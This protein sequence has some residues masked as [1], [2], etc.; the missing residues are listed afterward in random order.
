[1]EWSACKQDYALYGTE[2]Y[3]LFKNES[4]QYIFIGVE[5][6]LGALANAHTLKYVIGNQSRQ[7]ME[8]FHYDGKDNSRQTC[9]L[10]LDLGSY[11]ISGAPVNLHEKDGVG[12]K[13]V[14]ENIN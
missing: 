10:S 3:S 13:Y 14:Y 11:K 6:P 2:I 12:F 4:D 8:T 9:L 7:N 5:C 1:M